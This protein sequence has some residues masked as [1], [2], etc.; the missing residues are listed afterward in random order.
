[1]A[2][3]PS[4]HGRST[5]L[6]WQAAAAELASLRAAARLHE[7]GMARAQELEAELRG[8]LQAAP[9]EEGAPI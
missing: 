2:G 6:I 5:F 8:T 4:S 3:A 9:Y 7:G 1:M